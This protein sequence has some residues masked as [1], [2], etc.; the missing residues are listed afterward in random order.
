MNTTPLCGRT[1]FHLHHDTTAGRCL[2]STGGATS[3]AE[4]LDRR[5]DLVDLTTVTITNRIQ[6]SCA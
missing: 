6:V 3:L 5:P 4:L 1:F 2:G